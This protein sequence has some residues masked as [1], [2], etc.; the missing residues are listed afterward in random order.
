MGCSWE[1]NEK[2]SVKFTKGKKYMRVSISISNEP[3]HSYV[4]RENNELLNV[5]HGIIMHL[6][7]MIRF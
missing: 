7:V 2:L 6:F 3:L 1:P 4:Q 5:S